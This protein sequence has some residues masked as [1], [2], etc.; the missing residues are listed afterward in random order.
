M[1][2]APNASISRQ[3]APG[4]PS[5]TD[6]VAAPWIADDRGLAGKGRLHALRWLP[7]RDGKPLVMRR[8]NAI[9]RH[10]FLIYPDFCEA[11]RF[12]MRDHRVSCEKS[13]LDGGSGASME[14]Q[15]AV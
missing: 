8:K 3:G 15:A 10:L 12:Q 11:G 1:N 5:R 9:L 6:A 4:L 13:H 7:C 2:G 14:D